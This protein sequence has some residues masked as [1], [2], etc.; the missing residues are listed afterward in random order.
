MNSKPS[1][2]P[3]PTRKQ[4]TNIS[5]FFYSKGRIPQQI[6]SKDIKAPTS[7][8]AVISDQKVQAISSRK[9]QKGDKTLEESSTKSKTSNGL[10]SPKKIPKSNVISQKKLQNQEKVFFDVV[11]IH[12][13]NVLF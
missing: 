3:S 8:S 12:S 2:S 10:R 11:K 5:K 9:E 7:K 13:K 1:A 6:T 4:N